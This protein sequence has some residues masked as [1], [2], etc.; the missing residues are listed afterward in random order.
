MRH[1]ERMRTVAG[2]VVVAA[3]AVAV[4]VG[5]AGHA[6]HAV[7]PASAADRVN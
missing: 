7:T 6:P 2:A 4:A 5:L 1:S 3:V